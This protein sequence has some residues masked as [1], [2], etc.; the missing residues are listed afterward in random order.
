MERR[1]LFE[2][3]MQQRAL[4]EFDGLARIRALVDW[5]AFVPTLEEIFGVCHGG[6][7]RPAWDP[8]VMFRSILLGVMHSLSDRD[9]QF[10]LLDRRTFK[11]FAGLQSDDQVPDQKT[12]W[13][14]RDLLSRSGRIDELFDLFKAQLRSHGYELTSGQLVDSSIVEV[15]RQRNSREDNRTV[16]SGEVPE[17]W[18]D[19]PNKLCQKDT[20]AR[21][22]KKRNQNHY[23]YKNHISADRETKFIDEWEVTAASTHDSQVFVELLP[24]RPEG[25]C[26]VWADSAY[27]SEDALRKLRKRGY[28]PRV[29]HKATRAKAL[30]DRQDGVNRAYSKVRCR[31]EHVF[32]SMTNEMPERYMRCIGKTRARTWI[33]LRNLCYNMRRLSYLQ[34]SLSA[35]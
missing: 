28:K 25:D 35:A 23:G 1:H 27:R 3:E 21:W 17:S 19:N 20:D 26:Q 30:S 32:G 8:L 13:K 11:Q 12:L 29:N 7:G 15:P 16:K 24:E 5:Q 14:Y 18:Q 4:E 10:M 31:V 34:P 9:L 22:T 6:P 33:G 2:R